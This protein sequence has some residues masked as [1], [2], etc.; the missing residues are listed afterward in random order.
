MSSWPA[1]LGFARGFQYMRVPWPAV[2]V[3]G[4]NLQVSF[5]PRRP[6][7]QTSVN[8]NGD[9]WTVES[10]FANYK[11]HFYAVE[12]LDLK[13]VVVEK[14]VD[15]IM[16]DFLSG[17]ASSIGGT[18]ESSEKT[19]LAR[20]T[21]TSF[22]ISLPPGAGA[23]ERKLPVKARIRG[24]MATRGRRLFIA[25]PWPERRSVFGRHTQ[26]IQSF[27]ISTPPAQLN[28]QAPTS[29]TSRPA[30]SLW[31]RRSNSR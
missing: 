2:R 26:F 4:R 25:G 27:E 11:G 21:A 13:V 1:R 22:V 7:S 5:R 10:R 18:I 15:S 23:G 6:N 30:R 20:N 17:W 31:P 24:L 19:S 16:K 9:L 3:A 28:F 8:I 14:N 12:Y 29:G